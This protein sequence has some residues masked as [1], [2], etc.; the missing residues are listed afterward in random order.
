MMGRRL[1]D[2][3]CNRCVA[4]RRRRRGAAPLY[5]TGWMAPAGKQGEHNVQEMHNYQQGYNP[6]SYQQ[7]YYGQSSYN[8]Y[9][10]P[11]P[12]YGQQQQQQPQHTG[13]TFTP[14]EGYYGDSPQPQPQQ[15]Y[16]VQPPPSSYQPDA[17]YS[18]PAG[19]PPAK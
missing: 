4:R 7:G 16:G 2:V 12:A 8:G 1:T 5:G 17:T 13:Q 10:N 9:P 14:S 18:P 3:S 6:Q 15:Q 11:P 19:P